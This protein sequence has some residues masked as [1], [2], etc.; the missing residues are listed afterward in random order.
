MLITICGRAGSK[1][2]KNKNLKSLL[3]IPLVY[4]SLANAMYLKAH[5]ADAQVDI[6]LN[7]DS[8]EL[9]GLVE[10]ARCGVEIIRRPEYL[11]GGTVGKF[12]VYKHCLKVMEE[13]K[14]YLYD[15]MIDLDITSP[16]RK[17]DDSLNA[18][19]CHRACPDADLTITGCPSRRNPYFNMVEEDGSFVKKVINIPIEARQQAPKVYDMNASIYVLRSGFVRDENQ[20]LI[21]NGRSII[22]QMYDTAILDIDSEEDFELMTVIAKYLF[23]GNKEFNEMYN[24]TKAFYEEVKARDE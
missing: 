21:L 10:K 8:E 4:Y 9:I 13:R 20:H 14:G 16:M 17:L 3:G 24:A 12:E 5:T 7:T 18:L 1:G 22:Y 11:C 19:N 6:C 15:Y 23:E 2:F